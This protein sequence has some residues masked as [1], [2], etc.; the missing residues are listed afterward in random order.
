MSFFSLERYREKNCGVN[1]KKQT[2]G[3]KLMGVNSLPVTF[4]FSQA[5]QDVVSASAD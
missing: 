3:K 4:H 1:K 2:A 5:K